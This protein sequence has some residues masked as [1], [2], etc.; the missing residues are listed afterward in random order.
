[1]RLLAALALLSLSLGSIAEAQGTP[2]VPER[3]LALTRD[4]DF[5][6]ADLQSLFDTTLNACEAAC[7]SDDR[8]VAF[9]FNTRSNA[10]FTKSAVD[11]EEPYVG[12]F[13]ATVLETAPAVMAAAPDRA[14]DL[15]G[16]LNDYDLDSAREL[17]LDLTNDHV[18]GNWT[19]AA[20][21][22]SAIDARANGNPLAAYRYT[23]AAVV[24]SDAADQWTE[25]ARLALG[26]ETDNRAEQQSY[27]RRAMLASINAYLRADAA[28]VRANAL[29][30][31]AEALEATGRGREMIP[32]LRLAQSLAPRD[33]T[34]ALLANAVG[35]YGFR[36]VSNTVEAD[37]ATP[38]VCAEF[39]EELVQAGVDYAPFV[40]FPSQDLTVEASGRQLCVEG[41]THGQRY[42]LTFRQG[43]PAANG[44]TM[45]RSATITAYV[46][47]RSPTVRFPG[48]AYVLPAAGDIA[49]PVVTVNTDE[50]GLTL[51]RVS[52]RAILTAIQEDFFGR[53][54]SAWDEDRFGDTVAE[55]VWTGTGEVASTLNEDVTTRLPMAEVVGRLEPG[56][57]ALRAVVP[58]ADLYET[59]AAMQW[60]V[61]SDLG[62][63]T[64]DGT[65]G[66]HVFLR[67]LA[68]AEPL[69]GVQV[70]LLSRANA[71]LGEGAT[72]ASG[73]ARFDP[74]LMRGTGGAAPALVLARQGEGDLTFLSLTDP[75]FDLSDRGVEGRAPAGPVDAFLTTDRGAYR[76]GET[77]NA[78]V[79]MRDAKAEAIADLP[80]I[81][82]LS[83]PDGVEY[84]REISQGGKAGGH[85]FSFGTS[86]SVPRGAW[87]LAVYADPDAAALASTTVLVEDFLPE[88]IDFDLSMPDGLIALTDRPDLSIDARYLFGAPGADLPVEGEVLL[89]PTR[90]LE[91]WPGY[92]FGR[93]D[94]DASPRVEILPS[95]LRT[96]DAGMVSVPVTFPEIDQTFRP[97]EAELRV[98]VA[99]GSGRP[100]ERTLTRAVAP[101]RPVLGIKPNFDG[102]LPEGGEASFNL[103]A[104]DEAQAATDMDVRW[105]ISRVERRYQWYQLDGYWEWEPVTTRTQVASGDATLGA[106]PLT[107]TAPVDW[108]SYEISVERLG[109][110]YVAAS[111]EFYAGWYGAADASA[112]PDV[113]EVSLDAESYKPGDTARLRIVPRNA[114]RALITVVSNRLIDMK[115]VSVSAG[116]NVIDLPVT[117][118]WG[119]GAYVTATVI[120]PMDTESDRNPTRALGLSYAPVDPGKHQLTADFEVDAEADPRGPLEVALKVSGV[121]PGE[122]AYATIAAVDVGILNLTGFETPDPSGHYFGQR[123]LGV[124]MRDVYGRLIDGMTGTMGAVRS[125]GDA[126]SKVNA[127]APPPA[128]ELLA[129]FSGPIT[130]DGDGYARA[131]FDLPSFNGTVK[132]MA[133][134]WSRM[135]VGEAEAEVLVRDPVVV[136]ASLPRFLAPGDT[137]RLLLEV[138]HAS[139]PTGRMGLD[140]TADGV[141]LGGD[142]PSGI[143]LAAGGKETLSIPIS[144]GDPGVHSI[145]VS[146]TTPDGK[147]LT[148]TL[149]LPVEAND[150]EVAETRRFELAAGDTFSFTDDVFADFR[151]GTGTATLAAGPLARM[152]APG[153][154]Q[155]LNRYP[156][157]CT[158]QTTS[159]AMPL[160]YLSEVATAM[161]LDTAGDLQDRI[162]GA[163]ERVLSNQDSS[164]S[165]GLWGPSS[166]D[167]WLDAYVSDF[168]SRARAR[169]VTVP[170]NAFRMAMDNLR[171]RVNY[172]PD[173]DEG[174][175]DIAYALYVLAREGAAAIGDLRYYA[176][177]KAEGLATPL[178]KAQLGAALAA[179]GDPTRADRLFALAQR[180]IDGQDGTEGQL[181]RADYGTHLRDRAAVLT[182]ALEAGS[183]AVDQNALLDSIAP[184]GD[185]NQW[186]TQEQVWSLLAARALLGQTS[187]LTVNGA[188]PQGPLVYVQ[189]AQTA[190]APLEIRNTGDGPATITL[191]RF[192]VPQVPEPKG[193][194]GYAIDR[195]YFTLDGQPADP[196]EVETGTRLLTVLTVQP[197]GER[198]ARLMVDDPLPAGFEIDN[199]NLLRGGDIRALDWL[200]L[201]TD[202]RTT[203]FRQDRFLA[204]VDWRGDQAF[205]LGY[206]VRAISPG[207]Y[208]HPAAS[209]E[210]MYRPA[211]RAR[212]EAGEVTITE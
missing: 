14:R 200:D 95:G 152:D 74:G 142:V 16:F 186:S 169:G 8:C 105:T 67:S 176:D 82:V 122:T 53:P 143:D 51:R 2:P 158:E 106:A 77:I 65:D 22:Q 196:A 36:V 138:V 199:P 20:L 113:L 170:D 39:S 194:N 163:V 129:Y 179:Y 160:L 27:Q 75:E 211:F 177:V 47:D 119:A 6:G 116:E 145:A 212:T 29:V 162:D 38:R 191:T 195:T 44:E 76:A 147:V 165:F 156:Y 10:C 21:L 91:N 19:V 86:G 96:D 184:V 168:L 49:L 107:V 198:E 157:G 182:L 5:P 80:A 34:E 183:S 17:A 54:L 87:R 98:R 92:V 62:L 114:G 4:V 108:G 144:A 166:G 104:L 131:T 167:F 52:D 81:A 15:R 128:E 60:F 109:G 175:E 164:G 148:K 84:S 189:E 139:G 118:A 30:T 123:K 89:R 61:V 154:L 71:V 173:F 125:G 11:A 18:P 26:I 66:L 188:K 137:S 155:A 79:L 185:L 94:E 111:D 70:T 12:A 103:I 197:L 141:T 136:T 55:T 149:S 100:V 23:G 90:N 201:T 101:G 35:K 117:D 134:A 9:T 33:D 37:S 151:A 206:I 190:F 43:L 178:A 7:L 45:A 97:L 102:T 50:I 133:V 83:R 209:V 1:M 56:I 69:E 59:P 126:M 31:L 192:G 58:D 32:A 110:E 174:G 146:L 48:R 203:E 172:A 72:D 150:P 202:T 171:N 40:Q 205:R 57:Y 121:T 132:L 46:R 130:V 85:V 112:T 41:V 3:R 181:W 210:D 93:H 13:S 159:R 207:T 153:L 63:A 24:L 88:R 187:D 127:D 99:E 204:A 208:H 73:H 25:Y 193:G 64:L 135:G 78:T 124:G 115:A 28:P 120:R 161:N 68:S 180:Q 140:V 42:E